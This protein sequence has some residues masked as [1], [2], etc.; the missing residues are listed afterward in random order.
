LSRAPK[1]ACKS[2][3]WNRAGGRKHGRS[4]CPS[5]LVETFQAQRTL[6]ERFRRISYRDPDTGK[7]LAFLTNN[8]ELPALTIAQ[9]YK[10]RW[11][12]E[13]FFKWIK[14]NSRIKHFFGTPDNAVKTQVSHLGLG[15]SVAGHGCGACRRTANRR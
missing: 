15:L 8:F 1:Q 11:R 6:P 2:T 5:G 9:F 13:L 10:C 4:Q 7:A 12:V 14:Q 3:D